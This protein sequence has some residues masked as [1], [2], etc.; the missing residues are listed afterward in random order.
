MKINGFKLNSKTKVTDLVNDMM[1]LGFQ[2]SHVS[3]A[4][5]ILKSARKDKSTLFLSCTSNIISSGLREIIAQLCRHKI[6]DVII[7]ST[8][9]IEEDIM[10]T[11]G[12]FEL[13]DFNVDD[14]SL[15]KKGINRIGNIFVKNKHYINFERFANRLLTDLNKKIQSKDNFKL[16]SPSAI[17]DEMGARVDDKNSFLYWCHKNNIP[18]FCPGITDGAFGL[19]IYFFKKKHPRFGIDVTGDMGKLAEITLVADK[20]AGIFLGGGIAKHHTI[21][22]N[23]LRDGL[24]YAVYISTATEGDGSLSGAR[25]KEAVTWSKIREKAKSVHIEGDASIIF[26]MLA[27]CMTEIYQV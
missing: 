22:V 14:V 7:T 21:G 4:V 6:I 10:K 18:V 11:M 19:N 13:G 3:Q 24:D 16:P 1:G 9:A 2:A 8:G 17:I 27:V 25:P 20:T 26:P 23:I 12:D 5:D 15:H